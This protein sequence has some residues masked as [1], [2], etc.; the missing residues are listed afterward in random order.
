MRPWSLWHE[1]ARD[2]AAA[3]D[4]FLDDFV[5]VGLGHAA[6]P[7]IFRIDNDGRAL[8]A[9]IE[10]AGLIG[11]NAAV[12]AALGE[13]L[14]ERLLQ[15]LGPGRIAGAAHVAGLAAVATNEQVLVERGHGESGDVVIW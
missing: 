13:G 4:V 1:Q 9:L 10:T 7:D 14:L 6:V 3:D 12:D 5:D 2:R 11:A 15:R 8:L